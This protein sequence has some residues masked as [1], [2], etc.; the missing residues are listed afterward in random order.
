MLVL[1][2]EGELDGSSLT[3]QAD[4]QVMQNEG[5]LER[6]SPSRRLGT[7]A[8]SQRS[9]LLDDYVRTRNAAFSEH[10]PL[11]RILRSSHKSYSS[12]TTG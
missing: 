1:E 4:G 12:M 9:P 5:D 8:R 3:P 7:E 11:M 2:K 10:S 6:M